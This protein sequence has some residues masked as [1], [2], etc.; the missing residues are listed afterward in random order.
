MSFL[1]S[2]SIRI[3]PI[4]VVIVILSG[5][6][7]NI[8]AGFIKTLLVQ[9][10][11]GLGG[12]GLIFLGL[13]INKLVHE[14]RK[15]QEKLDELLKKLE[16]LREIQQETRQDKSGIVI[17]DVI[18]SG[19]KFYADYQKKTRLTNNL[20]SPSR[21]QLKERIYQYGRYFIL[22]SLCPFTSNRPQHTGMEQSRGKSCG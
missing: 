14:E 6:S 7:I 8:T 18:N 22:R 13:I 16:E 11:M 21:Q 4:A 5:I 10:A 12:V 19:L 20:S 2:L 1:R 17:A 9:V 15:S 3:Y